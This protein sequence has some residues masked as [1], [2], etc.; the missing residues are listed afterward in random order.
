MAISNTIQPVNLHYAHNL[1]TDSIAYIFVNTECKGLP[2]RNA[3]DRGKQAK[4]LFNEV[5]EFQKVEVFKNL[6]KV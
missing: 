3:E 6:G 5:L 2:Y 1:V 4:T